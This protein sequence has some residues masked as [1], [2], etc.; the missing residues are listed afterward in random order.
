MRSMWLAFFTV[1]GQTAACFL[2]RSRPRVSVATQELLG[3]GCALTGRGKA[4][5]DGLHGR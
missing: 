3:R 4:G 1:D 2:A 5:I